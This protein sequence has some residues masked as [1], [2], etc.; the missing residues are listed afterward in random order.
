VESRRLLDIRLISVEEDIDI[1]E[2]PYRQLADELLAHAG[3]IGVKT[4]ETF[5]AIRRL[6]QDLSYVHD[7]S[8]KD[9]LAMVRM[10]YLNET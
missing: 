6:V 9:A 7:I 10:A 5:F 8:T 4:D 2:A 1:E 3:L